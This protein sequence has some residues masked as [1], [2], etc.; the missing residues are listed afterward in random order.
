[1][2]VDCRFLVRGPHSTPYVDRRAF[3]EVQVEW[4]VG[5]D[6]FAALDGFAER[7]DEGVLASTQDF[8]PGGGELL[9]VVVVDSSVT[10]G[11]QVAETQQLVPRVARLLGTP[12]AL[13]PGLGGLRCVGR[14]GWDDHTADLGRG[15]CWGLLVVGLALRLRWIA[16]LVLVALAFVALAAAAAPTTARLAIKAATT[17]TRTLPTTVARWTLVG[18]VSAS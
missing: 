16:L 1:M 14:V 6:G 7:L 12:D 3:T 18:P 10:L 4:L 8:Q 5:V 13:A 15:C 2:L 17:A 9:G 11:P